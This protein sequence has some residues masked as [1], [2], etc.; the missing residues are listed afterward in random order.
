MYHLVSACDRENV[1]M[2]VCMYVCV[3]VC[4]AL[5]G[6]EL[7]WIAVRRRFNKRAD[8]EEKVKSINQFY[9]ACDRVSGLC[10]GVSALS[11]LCLKNR[12]HAPLSAR[13]GAAAPRRAAA[14]SCV[15]LWRS[16][17]GLSPSTRAEHAEDLYVFGASHLLHMLSMRRTSPGGMGSISAEECGRSRRWRMGIDTGMR[18]DTG[19]AHR[20]GLDAR[21]RC[22]RSKKLVFLTQSQ[23]ARGDWAR[24]RSSV[25]FD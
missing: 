25:S 10:G 8:H 3:C 9:T 18:I 11:E 24:C 20:R 22:W 5:G 16:G 21:H 17:W 2:Y 14:L 7:Q 15:G 19:A 13:N 6:W 12:V 23:P 1:C 4:A